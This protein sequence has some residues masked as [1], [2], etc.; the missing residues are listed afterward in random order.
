MDSIVKIKL[1]GGV[2]KKH[3]AVKG[4][5]FDFVLTMLL[6]SKETRNFSTAAISARVNLKSVAL[7][8]D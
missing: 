1:F 6:I 4:V 8:F 5:E 3:A 2:T 7:Y